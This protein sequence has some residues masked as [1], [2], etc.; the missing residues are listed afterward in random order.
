MSRKFSIKSFSGLSN[1]EFQIIIE[2]NGFIRKGRQN[3]HCTIF[4]RK[5]R[6]TKR[7]VAVQSLVSKGILQTG[8]IRMNLVSY[9]FTKGFQT[10]KA[11]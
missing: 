7:Y 10:W 5:K 8:E 3:G 6:L 1:L 2:L 4:N 11:K 9:S